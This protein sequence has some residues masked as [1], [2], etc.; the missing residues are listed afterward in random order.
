MPLMLL[1][2]SAFDGYD[3]FTF[4][5]DTGFILN[6]HEFKDI[7][8]L[9]FTEIKARIEDY[10]SIYFIS[11]SMGGIIVQSLLAEQVEHRNQTFIQSVRGIVYLAVPFLGSSIASAATIPYIF[12]PPILGE[13]VVSIQVRSLKVFSKDLSE[14]ADKWNRYRQKELAHLK[15]LNL[16]GQSDKT[17]AVPSARA[18]YITNSYAVPEGHISICKVDQNNTV[19]IKVR[20]FFTEQKKNIVKRKAK[21]G[22][23]EV[24]QYIRWIKLRTQNFIVPGANVPLSIEHAWASLHVLEESNERKVDSLEKEIAKYHE[25]ERL[26]HRYKRKNA[27]EIMELG[28]RIILIGGPGSG[29]STLARRAVNRLSTKGEKVLYVRLPHV[30]KEMEQGKSFE[31][32]LWSVALDGYAGDKE[33]LQ[34][35]L[36]Y[37]NILIADGLDECGLLRRRVSE[38]LYEWSLGRDDSR[39]VVTTRPIGYNPA[40]FNSFNHVEILPLDETEISTYSLKLL[41]LLNDHEHKA[42]EMNSSFKTQLENNKMAKV[43]A[44]SPLLLNFLIL[45]HNSGQTYGRYRAELYNKILEVWIKQSDRVDGKNLNEQTV[46]RSIEL[47]GWILQ[48]ASNGIG[49]RSKQDIT[50]QL[51]SFIE[52]ELGEKPLKARQV[53]SDC[54]DF[55]KEVGLLEEL[56]AGYESGYTFIHLSLGEYA[57][58]RYIA[59]LSSQQQIE[60]FRENKHSPMWR[61][62]LLLAAGVGSARLFV[63]YLICNFQE[64]HDI[65]NDVA[66]LG[67]ILAESHPLPDLNR[68]VVSKAIDTL[69]SSVPILCF[70]AGKAL[71]GIAQ[72]EPD[73]T[74]SLVEPLLQHNQSW[75]KLVAYKLAI[76]TNKL[77]VDVNKINNLITLSPDSS[78]FE[79]FNKLKMKEEWLEWNKTIELAMEKLLQDDSV[80]DSHLIKVLKDLKEVGFNARFHLNIS[81]KFNELGKK[82]LLNILN[83]DLNLSRFDFKSTSLK[84]VEGEK[85]LLKSILRNISSRKESSF[86]VGDS[87]SELGKLYHCMGLGDS[88]IYDLH[89]LIDDLQLNVVDEVIKGMMLVHGTDKDR[90]YDEIQWILQEHDSESIILSMIPDVIGLEPNWDK[91]DNQLNRDLLIEGLSYPSQTIASN[92]VLLLVNCFGKEDLIEPI[93]NVLRE[94]K[95]ESLFYFSMLLKHAFEG[96]CIELVLERLNGEKSNGIQYLFNTLSSL[97]IQNYE[98]E[99]DKAL[100]NGIKNNEPVIVKSAA[101]AM[102]NLNRKCN[103]EEIKKS[104]SFWNDNGVK[105]EKDNINV[106]GSHCPECKVVP[107]SPLPDLIRLLRESILLTF[108]ERKYFSQHPRQDVKEAGLEVLSIYLSNN[109]RDIKGLV[110]DICSEEESPILLEA[111]FAIDSSI[112]VTYSSEILLLI[113][114]NSF[115]VRKKLVRELS[116]SPWANKD[117]SITVLENAL[118]DKDPRVRNEAVISMRA[119]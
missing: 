8:N 96:D 17:V 36:N 13:S 18:P 70:E 3:V 73:W 4:G 91:G 48:N 74:F 43:A 40:H 103:E 78:A 100:I 12:M 39:V 89:P 30:A 15:E 119:M 115:E 72:Q 59:G 9:L 68:I 65:H 69:C 66:F 20:A 116:S 88:P 27:Q 31:N 86:K 52:V 108:E 21:N 19:Y 5:Y 11:H 34:T 29:K 37:S 94:A 35:E 53:A 47:I 1:E 77:L 106:I 111:L 90:I 99:I 114:S 10:T 26:S 56:N 55:L 80:D 113:N 81:K 54:L 57:A 93:K 46:F 50:E 107:E 33:L 92:A 104:I 62:P 109:P 87:V 85:A 102:I 45:L 98:V 67:A 25:W 28:T 117:N 38:S 2:D 76:L 14:N 82:D 44:R 16:Y 41:G 22:Q 61:E 110:K 6:R 97:K 105:C 75:T 42:K 71:E 83:E 32:A 118:N 63:E 49:G 58:G 112:L 7:S 84:M 101:I 60:I 51:A 24:S 79:D 64:E 95:G 23:E